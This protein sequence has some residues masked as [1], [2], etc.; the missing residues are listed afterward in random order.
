MHINQLA[1]GF[2]KLN[3]LLPFGNNEFIAPEATTWDQYGLLDRFP[4]H[5]TFTSEEEEQ[6]LDLT[7]HG[8]EAYGH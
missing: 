7:Q 6:G 5:L 4:T 2:D 3:R 8:E 1:E